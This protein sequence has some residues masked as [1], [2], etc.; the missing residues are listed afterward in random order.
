MPITIYSD[1]EFYIVSETHF[2]ELVR[3][4]FDSRCLLTVK[5]SNKMIKLFKLPYLHL[6]TIAGFKL[7]CSTDNAT[8]KLKWKI[9]TFF[10]ISISACYVTSAFHHENE[11]K[12]M[13]Q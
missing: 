12:V 9:F 8:I 11:K 1:R 3:D 10:E 2:N 6:I 7:V 4:L 5:R 13:F